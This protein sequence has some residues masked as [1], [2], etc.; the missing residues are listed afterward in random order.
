MTFP[1]RAY[2]VLTGPQLAELTGAGNFAGAP[3]DLEDGYIHLS[4]EGQLAETLVKHFAG[5]ADLWIVEVDLIALHDLVRWEP[6]RGGALF[7]HVYGDLPLSAVVAHGPVQW[8]DGGK[9][10][11]PN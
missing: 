3:V 9:I 10:I 8:D 2:K 4:T 11:L 7:P 1:T 5:Q 6:S